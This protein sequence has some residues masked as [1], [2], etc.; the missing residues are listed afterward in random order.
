MRNVRVLALLLAVLA[1]SIVT[2]PA[3][4]DDNA[5]DNPLPVDQRAYQRYERFSVTPADGNRHFYTFGVSAAP[6]FL[7]QV[8]YL[9]NRTQ[10]TLCPGLTPDCYKPG[11]DLD[12]IGSLPLCDSPEQ[13]M[14][15]AGVWAKSSESDWVKATNL[16]YVDLTPNASEL[17]RIEE[18]P[19]YPDRI[20]L[21]KNEVV[22]WSVT[23]IVPASAPGSLRVQFPGIQ[24]A[25]GTETYIVKS[26]FDLQVRKGEKKYSEF[27]TNIIPYKE[28]VL[29][30]ADTSVR[31]LW[32][33][34]T[35]PDILWMGQS[36]ATGDATKFAWSEHG[37]LGYAA[38][39]A[40][41]VTFRLELQL[42][43][44]IGGW[45]HGR[46]NDPNLKIEPIGPDA[47]KLS[48][49]AKPASVPVTAA[50]MP[51]IKD[52]EIDKDVP[53]NLPESD[54]QR[55]IADDAAGRFGATGSIWEPRSGL[56][57]FKSHL[58][59]LGDKAKGQ[60]SVWSIAAMTYLPQGNKCLQEPG[61]LHGLVTT[62]AM[63]YQAGMPIFENGY[64]TYQVG[65]LH[66]DWA[67]RVITGNYD[68]LLRSES[69]RCLYG[70][71]SAPVYASIS[72]LGE[73]GEAKVASTVVSERDGWLKLAA[74]GFTFSEKTIKV[75]LIQE[76]PPTPIKSVTC[77]KGSS[78][79]VVS[80]NSPK[81]PSGYVS[82]ATLKKTTLTCVR[83]KV[84]RVVTGVLP[85]CPAG[86][87]IS[88]KQS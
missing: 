62:D 56:Q 55:V 60:A 17:S 10:R 4:G 29:S 65:G 54:K 28:G 12:A 40:G 80:G 42:P 35:N 78:R 87:K 24:N 3:A 83:G 45:F 36:G 14:C 34:R 50:W 2:P 25:A 77:A 49:E 69:A 46:M 51:F 30:Y 74:R 72:V 7:N 57:F 64:L 33:S 59:M 75:Q 66:Y 8:P 39:F 67:G 5:G 31:M 81:C 84:T 26:V 82:I 58:P 22:S 13:T 18:D 21:D 1:S 43:T 32:G 9:I 48:V 16:G 63:V 52:G 27:F 47:I 38:A 70:F 41:D 76:K 88:S 20:L 15:I 71:S 6:G 79:K 19:Q 86:F 53:Q 73:A 44:E 23:N 68:L 37:R 85:K 61:I 11:D